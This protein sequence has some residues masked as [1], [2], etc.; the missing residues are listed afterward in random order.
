MTKKVLLVDDNPTLLR[1]LGRV[2]EERF[3]IET[4]ESGT[5]A[6]EMLEQEAFDVLISDFKMPSM[7]GIQLVTQ[8]QKEWPNTRCMI[9]TGNQDEDSLNQA[10]NIAKAYRLLLKPM[11]VTELINAI[12]EAVRE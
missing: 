2:L 6:L 10:T 1:A 11:P 9:L 7:N 3:D 4:A 5:R 12:E 8:V